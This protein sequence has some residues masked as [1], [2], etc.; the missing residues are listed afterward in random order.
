MRCNGTQCYG[1]QGGMEKCEK[2]EE[3]SEATGEG[4]RV[5]GVM[6]GYG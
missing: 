1:M 3:K 5:V 2:Q 4:V 6:Y